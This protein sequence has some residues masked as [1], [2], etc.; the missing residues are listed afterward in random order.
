MTAGLLILEMNF[1]DWFL[2]LL[3]TGI[4]W[5]ILG[6]RLQADIAQWRKGRASARAVDGSTN[7]DSA[8]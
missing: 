2:V 8:G 4:I 6:K 1:V 7:E 3:A 5:A